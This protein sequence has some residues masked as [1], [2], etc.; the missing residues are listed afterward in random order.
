MP[1]IVARRA[2]GAARYAALAVAAAAL[3]DWLFYD[4]PIGVSLPIFLAAVL[5]L[6]LIRR[7]VARA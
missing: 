2:P 7:S 4:R 6:I 5:T 3:A 1:D